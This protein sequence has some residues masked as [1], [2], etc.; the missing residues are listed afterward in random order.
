MLKS[1]KAPLDSRACAEAS[2][3]I[4]EVSAKQFKNPQNSH[5]CPVP[6]DHKVPF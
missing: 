4:F 2:S 5:L 6:E 3:S 1:T